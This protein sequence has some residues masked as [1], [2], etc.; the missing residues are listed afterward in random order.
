MVTIHK[1]LAKSFSFD[2]DFWAKL[3]FVKLHKNRAEINIF[4]VNML[5]EKFPFVKFHKNG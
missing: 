4:Y 3:P 1:Y 2:L 5:W